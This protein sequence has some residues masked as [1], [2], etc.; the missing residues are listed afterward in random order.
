MTNSLSPGDL[1]SGQLVDG[2]EGTPFQSCSL[3]YEPRIG[4][5]LS[6]PYIRDVEQFSATT[7]WFEGRTPPSL[8][9]QDNLGTVTFTGLR[10]R[11]M[12]GDPLVLGRLRA[13]VAIFG[14]PLELE[15]EYR[16]ATMAS[17]IDGL[18]N[19]ASFNSIDSVVEATDQGH[20]VIVTVE[21][22]ENITCEH[23][24]FQFTIRATT[25]WSA[26]RGQSFEAHAGAIL[27]T[28]SVQG[29]TADEHLTA[30]WPIRSLLVLAYGTKLYWRRHHIL[31]EKFPV[32]T[33]DGA[34]HGPDECLV[35]L[36][37]TVEDAEQPEHPHSSFA[38]PMF[39]L[40]DLGQSGVSRWLSLYEDPVFRKAI[41]PAV[42][43]INGASRFLEPQV[44]LAM[45][46]LD[47]MGY[48][49]DNARSRNVPL[50]VQ[51]ERCLVSANIDLGSIGT[52]SEI[53]RAMAN[54]NNDLKHPDRL[55]RPDPLQLNLVAKLSVAVM[56]LQLF[57]LLDLPDSS[58]TR[59]VGNRDVQDALDALVQADLSIDT[60]G[61]FIPR[62]ERSAGV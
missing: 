1:R 28:T 23:G 25:P 33:I 47:A 8:M 53:A 48:Y 32:R 60:N 10:R 24:G 22:T 34:T 59:F 41:E 46:A 29:A 58:R 57:S 42:E 9:F 18:G 11:S 50:S 7:D 3:S 19:F 31:D 17:K 62:G 44:L 2:V 55:Q 27:E 61:R 43:V 38:V 40:A 30:Q 5:V 36:R 45:L 35:L 56:R 13:N 21:A 39:H 14:E 12:T 4:P 54:V 15:P 16:I 52:N 51:I 26:T 49:L 37:R 20:R 6:I